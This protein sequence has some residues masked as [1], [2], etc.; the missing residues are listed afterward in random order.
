M[1][2]DRIEADVVYNHEKHG[3][4]LVT[5]IGEMYNEYPLS[6]GRGAPEPDPSSR[7]VYFYKQYDG[8]GGMS[9]N[10]L[11]EEVMEFARDA[12]KEHEFEYEQTSSLRVDD[13]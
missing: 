9:P 2:L 4:V 5:A 13:E 12:S 3:D 8:Y 1:T 6:G 11:S 7:L 10:P